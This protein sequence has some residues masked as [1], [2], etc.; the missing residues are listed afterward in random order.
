MGNW[1]PSLSDEKGWETLNGKKI[2]IKKKKQQFWGF[3]LSLVDFF[4]LG[5]L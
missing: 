2:K 3:F 5:T 4:C 1:A